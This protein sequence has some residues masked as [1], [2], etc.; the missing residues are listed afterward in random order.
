[1]TETSDLP[2]I[3]RRPMTDRDPA[4]GRLYRTPRLARLHRAASDLRRVDAIDDEEMRRF[5]KTC[6]MPVEKLA[7]ESIREIRL[8]E[9]ISPAVMAT[10]LHVSPK[11]IEAWE[12]G[13]KKP[14][15]L[16]LKVLTLVQKH[17]LAY[18]R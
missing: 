13:T 6:L 18:L 14:S 11:T 17:G 3:T 8:K 2:Q 16:A 1:M 15:G 10:T 4:T 5:D 12:A 9:G 7:P